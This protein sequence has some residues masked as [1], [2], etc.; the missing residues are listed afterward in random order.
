M[1]LGRTAAGKTCA[2]D[3]AEAPRPNAPDVLAKHLVLARRSEVVE[4]H[5]RRMMLVL[6][7]LLPLGHL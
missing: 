4:E 3:T 6:K 5:L 1:W 2:V 7:V